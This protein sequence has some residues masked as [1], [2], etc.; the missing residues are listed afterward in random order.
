MSERSSPV[1]NLARAIT[2]PFLWRIFAGV[3][4]LAV[5]P[6]PRMFS[7]VFTT[8]EEVADEQ[9]WT[10]PTYLEASR[11]LLRECQRGLLPPRSETT[12]AILSL[13]IN[14]W[15]DGPPTVLD[16]AG[17][18][19]IRYWT[20]RAAL[21]RPVRWR[22]VDHPRL[23]AVSR[24]VMG[25]SEQLTF[26]SELPAP[27]ATA[28]D[29][30]LVYSS[31]QYVE[32]QAELLATLASYQPRYIVLSRLMSLPRDSY[33]TRQRLH[34]H[35]TPCKVSSLR[36]IVDGLESRQY[37]QLLSLEDG[38]DLL[39]FFDESVAPEK[40]VGMERLVVFTRAS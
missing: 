38:L 29:I 15:P 3:A 4:R 7:G 24:E 23:A 18:T 20:L 13:L 35:A 16:W 26:E 32:R 17:G 19:G 9:P 33:V 2:P 27:G 31:L 8:F 10:Q 39:G 6:P 12:H 25:E 21:T 11:Q 37:R 1:K 14:D 34:G 30:A 36:E 40:R 22:V 5:A 28:V